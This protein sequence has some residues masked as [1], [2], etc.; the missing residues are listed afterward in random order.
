MLLSIGLFFV[1][2]GGIFTGGKTV[3]KLLKRDD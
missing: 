2:K 1:E 3:T